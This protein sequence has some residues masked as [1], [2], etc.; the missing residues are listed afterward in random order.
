MWLDNAITEGTWTGIV[1]GFM[2]SNV[3]I[4]EA[5]EMLEKRTYNDFDLSPQEKGIRA[6][7]KSTGFLKGNWFWGYYRTSKEIPT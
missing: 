7:L 6:G 1:T 5:K 2:S 3:L 4:K